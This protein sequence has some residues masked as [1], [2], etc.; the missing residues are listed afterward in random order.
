M[1]GPDIA[2]AVCASFKKRPAYCK[3][4]AF[5]LV[6]GAANNYERKLPRQDYAKYE[7]IVFGV[8]VVILI[9]VAL[10]MIHRSR[11]KKTQTND[12]QMEVNTA[13]ANYFS[14]RGDEPTK[15]EELEQK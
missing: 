8:I 4:D 11:T 2:K 3:N 14:L 5:N 7:E 15:E 1:T 6:V 12:I 9:N 10:V 13:V